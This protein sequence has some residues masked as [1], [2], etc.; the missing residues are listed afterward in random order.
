MEWLRSR[1]Q[2]SSSKQNIISMQCAHCRMYCNPCPYFMNDG[3]TQVSAKKRQ[4]AV[5]SF[6]RVTIH[7]HHNGVGVQVA[8]CSLKAV[9]RPLLP[10]P[11]TFCLAQCFAEGLLFCGSCM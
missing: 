2:N 5:E 11:C 4:A 8:L 9:R 10:M 7:G 3:T 6:N 1:I